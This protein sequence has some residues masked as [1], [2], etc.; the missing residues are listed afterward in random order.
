[1]PKTGTQERGELWIRCPYCGDSKRSPDKAHFSVNLRTGVYH[2][3]RCKAAGRLN[4]KQLLNLGLIGFEVGLGELDQRMD[5]SA[6]EFPELI[7]GPATPRASELPR[8]RLLA[9]GGDWDA[10]EMFDPRT[11]ELTGIYFRRGKESRIVGDKTYSWPGAPGALF[12][13]GDRPIRLVE[14]PWDVLEDRDVSVF[15]L[16]SKTALADLYGHQV[17]LCPDGDVWKDMRL[18]K[19]LLRTIDWGLRFSKSCYIQGVEWIA[20]GKDPDEV[21]PDKRDFLERR[22]LRIL[23]REAKAAGKL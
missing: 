8:Q 15:G 22:Q 12:S 5:P 19:Q 2:C 10:F 18:F 23:I 20:D 1:M 17:V 11:L 13:D 21:P 3:H 7:P 4:T 6:A 14:G 16:I 9:T